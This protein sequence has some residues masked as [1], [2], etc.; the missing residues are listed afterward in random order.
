MTDLLSPEYVEV[1]VRRDESRLID[2]IEL[3]DLPPSPRR[4]A[5]LV[6]R[7]AAARAPQLV[8]DEPTAWQSLWPVVIS[9][10]P[11]AAY[12]I[13]ATVIR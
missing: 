8:A 11:A 12:V 1:P 10:I 6:A 9:Q 2:D 7:R 13:A 4:A 5:D 3:A